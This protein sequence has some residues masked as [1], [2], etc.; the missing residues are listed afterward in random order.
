VSTPI[1]IAVLNSG[2]PAAFRVDRP[3]GSGGQGAVFLGSYNGTEAALKLFDP[4]GDPRR[5]ERELRLLAEIDC[6]NLVKLLDSTTVT[7]NGTDLTLVAYEYHPGGTLLERLTPQSPA[8]TVD[9]LKRM[10][11]EISTAIESLWNKR[12]VHRDVKP[13][14]IV[15]ARDGRHI[16]VDVGLARHIDLSD[17]TALGAIPGTRGYMSPEQARGRRNLT[18][19]AD[20]FSLGVTVYEYAAKTHPYQ[21]DQ[22]Q[23]PRFTPRDLAHFRNDLP[24]LLVRLIHEMMAPSAARRPRDPVARFSAI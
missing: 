7:I 3:L 2:L 21:R 11:K 5:I 8:A 22:A 17:I 15:L 23:I 9:E 16:L 14:N 20:V 4:R 12:I 18:I 19:H 1:T 10:G 13:A 6:P 24:A